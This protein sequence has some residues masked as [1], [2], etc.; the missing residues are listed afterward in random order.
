MKTPDFKKLGLVVKPVPKKAG[1]LRGPV[2]DWQEGKELAARVRTSPGVA[3]QFD[4]FIGLRGSDRMSGQGHRIYVT[5]R[6]AIR[7]LVETFR[8]G[9]Q[10]GLSYGF[11]E[12]E[13][14]DRVADR[15]EAVEKICP[16]VVTFA[17]PAGLHAKFTRRLTKA[18]ATKIERVFPMDD[19]MQDGLDGYISD[20]SGKGPL[21]VPRLLEEQ[22]IRL[23]WD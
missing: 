11:D 6:L 7:E 1:W 12:D 5:P 4:V 14:I 10:V 16:F 9:E 17:D 23:W 19:S 22:E 2:I 3:D 8:V 18:A 13:T 20:W 15:L 21:L